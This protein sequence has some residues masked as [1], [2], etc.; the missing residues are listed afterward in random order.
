MKGKVTPTFFGDGEGVV[1][2]QDYQTTVV[3]AV[4][5]A[6]ERTKGDQTER[7]CKVCLSER[8]CCYHLL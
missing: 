1:S 4:A 7:F 2:H 5:W 3:I 8:Y 6:F